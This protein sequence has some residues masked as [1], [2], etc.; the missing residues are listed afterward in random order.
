MGGKCIQQGETDFLFFIFYF[1]FL[2]FHPVFA[3][4]LHCGACCMFFFFL[5]LLLPECLIE[6]CKVTLTF[7]YVDEIL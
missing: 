7:H 2:E 1:F 5:T 4:F 3:F 6:F